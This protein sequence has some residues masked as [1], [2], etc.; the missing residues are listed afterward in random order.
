MSR[1]QA[2]VKLQSLTLF[3]PLNDEVEAWIQNAGLS[4]THYDLLAAG[5]I[6]S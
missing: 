6:R 4:Y 1:L 3:G 2:T 5:F